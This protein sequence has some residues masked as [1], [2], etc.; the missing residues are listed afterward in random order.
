QAVVNEYALVRNK[1]LNVG[2]RLATR[3]SLAK[4]SAEVKALIDKE[5]ATALEELTLDGQGLDS[6]EEREQ[7][8]RS[9]FAESS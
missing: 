7:A 9:R 4:S 6:T 3:V 2:S 5:I 8:V 1:L